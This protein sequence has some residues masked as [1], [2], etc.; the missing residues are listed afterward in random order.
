MGELISFEQYL[1]TLDQPAL[2]EQFSAVGQEPLLLVDASAHL[3]YTAPHVLPACPV[4][5]VADSRGRLPAGSPFDLCI[6]ENQIDEV[7]GLIRRQS[8]ACAV[9]V[10]LLRHNEQADTTA[11]LFAE[12][13]CYS[14]LQQ[15]QGF[16]AWLAGAKRPEHKEDSTDLVLSE[17]QDKTLEI[18]LNRPRAHNAYSSALKDALSASLATAYAAADSEVVR[19]KGN[20]P[21]FCAGGDLSEFG[22]VSDAGL[23]HLSRTTRSAAALLANL[24]CRT[25]VLLHGACIGAGIEIPSFADYISVHPETFFQLPEINMGLVPGAGG[26]VG[27]TR[28]IGRQR[29]AYFAISNRRLDA[30]T[31]LVWGLIDN[32]D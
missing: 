10:Q 25:E 22:S 5:G 12:S 14:T 4:I 13:L 18:T 28:R 15:S 6:E 23:A 9:L 11:G 24:T 19:L 3:D 1:A 8:Q 7:T 26:T 27:I 20:G 30:E 29:T 17:W 32:I 21:S 31:A 16:R 2:K